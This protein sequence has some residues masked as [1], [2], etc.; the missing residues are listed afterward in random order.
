MCKILKSKIPDRVIT[1]SYEEL[2]KNPEKTIESIGT[3]VSQK[4]KVKNLG[5][6]LTKY[7]SE[8]LFRDHFAQLLA[9]H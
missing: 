2:I 5:Q 3:F 6:K 7:G 9:N 1:I 8:G 4:F